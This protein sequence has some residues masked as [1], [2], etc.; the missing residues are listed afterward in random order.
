MTATRKDTKYGSLAI[1]ILAI[2]LSVFWL[3][4][5]STQAWSDNSEYT[6]YLYAENCREI[7]ETYTGSFPSVRIQSDCR[8]SASTPR[9]HPQITTMCIN[10]SVVDSGAAYRVT[11][12]NQSDTGDTWRLD[13]NS[14][15]LEYVND[16]DVSSF[17]VST[18]LQQV[19]LTVSFGDVFQVV[20]SHVVWLDQVIGGPTMASS[21]ALKL[22][23]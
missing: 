19:S 7:C 5:C 9:I 14:H 10:N 4:S 20:N 18:A 12:N 16:G 21:R 15:P 11:M 3:E 8:C 2:Y 1:T 17:W 13:V 6:I 23:I 22:W